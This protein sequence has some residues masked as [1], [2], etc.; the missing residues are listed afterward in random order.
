MKSEVRHWVTAVFLGL[1]WFPTGA[2]GENAAEETV[3]VVAR[4]QETLGWRL[5]VAARSFR[6]RTFFEAIDL[7]ASLGQKHIEGFSG[8][9]VSTDIPKSLSYNLSEAEREAVVAKLRSAGITMPVYALERMPLDEESS[10]KVFEFAR[11]LNVETIVCEPA[12][13][14][15]SMIEELCDKYGINVAIRQQMSDAL[16]VYRGPEDIRK[17]CEGRSRR[18]GVCGDLGA[19]MRAGAKPITALPIVKDRLLTLHIHD[20]NQFGREGQDVPWGTGVAGLEEF[21]KEVYRLELKPALWTV[22]YPSGREDALTKI[23]LSI[24]F[25]NKV[26]VPIAD[27]HRNYIART[28]GVRRLSGVSPEERQKIER[29]IPTM[30][31]AVPAQPRKLL[32]IDLNVGRHGHPSIP[33][34]NLA[35]ELMGKKTGAYEAVFSNER[36]MLQP[37]N[38]GQFDAVFL[39]NTIGPLFDTPELRASF[40]AFIHDGGGLVANHAV[41]VTSEDW[42][43]FGEILGARGASHRDADEKVIIK[44][45]DPGNPINAAFAGRGFEL[46]DEIF[47][48]TDPYSREK[49][50]VLLSIDVDRTDMNQ[51]LPRGNC[52]R[53]DNDY[54]V[55]WIHQYGRGRVF[56]CSLGHNPYVFWDPMI[57]KHLLAGIQFA[58]GD[59]EANTTPSAGRAD[60]R[61]SR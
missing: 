60:D 3:R 30:A 2:R 6:D 18:V 54:A 56:Y 33:H 49:L 39:N 40:R 26:I 1:V 16:P 55:S 46:R 7:T 37:D 15:I 45:D 17:L 52:S 10:S 57:L 34:A 50:H 42:P 21:I 59:L 4:S 25:F 58:L 31:P 27:Y 53:A 20:L 5:G 43:E 12:P 38:L 35:V 41:T 48:F 9:K 36:S 23:A 32:V 28:A 22:E 19:W 47:R 51:G 29:A 24:E 13:E 61:N 8:Q 14:A 11:A 44:L